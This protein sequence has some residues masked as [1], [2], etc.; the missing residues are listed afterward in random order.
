MDNPEL[1]EKVNDTPVILQEEIQ[2]LISLLIK[3]HIRSWYSGFS[4]NQ[5][6]FDHF[7]TLTDQIHDT[8]SGRVQSVEWR[9]FF[10][11]RIPQ[12]FLRHVTDFNIARDRTTQDVS[13]DEAFQQ[14]QTH[15]GILHES[16]YLEDIADSLLICLL[17][18]NELMSDVAYCFTREL[19]SDLV[20]KTVIDRLSQPWFWDEIMLKSS[21]ANKSRLHQK[22]R[23]IYQFIAELPSRGFALLRDIYRYN[24]FSILGNCNATSRHEKISE[25]ASFRLPNWTRL[26]RTL[27][28]QYPAGDSIFALWI[29]QILSELLRPSECTSVQ[30]FLPICL[31]ILDAIYGDRLVH[32]FN[33]RLHVFLSHTSLA[34]MVKVCRI[35]LFPNDEPSTSRINPTVE[36]QMDLQ[37]EVIK[38][39]PAGVVFPFYNSKVINKILL[40]QVLDA[41]LGTIFPELQRRTPEQLKEKVARI[42]LANQ[43][44]AGNWGIASG[45]SRKANGVEVML[46]SPLSMSFRSEESH[47]Q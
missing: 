16:R 28:G 9:P 24:S 5:E 36:Q 25:A 2:H 41:L 32:A 4:Q 37:Q 10:S 1:F 22:R 27:V 26:A 15:R 42:R 47:N 3:Q 20:L 11:D 14:I 46:P 12:I 23:S 39:L 30:V 44:A 45:R 7:V 43:E 38:G 13:L 21:A 8:L 40:F 29:P 17:P 6:L 35:V 34:R 18:E 31:T 33:T 19:L